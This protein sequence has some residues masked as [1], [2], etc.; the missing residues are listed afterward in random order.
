MELVFVTPLPTICWPGLERPSPIPL[1]FTPIPPSV[2]LRRCLLP[3]IPLV[4]AYS[5][6]MVRKLYLPCPT[7][8]SWTSVMPG[9][10]ERKSGNNPA[11]WVMLPFGNGEHLSVIFARVTVLVW[12]TTRNDK[13]LFIHISWQSLCYLIGPISFFFFSTSSR[14]IRSSIT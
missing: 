1:L 12:F 5:M 13:V 2:M 6:R 4:T 3:T 11:S 14:R 8:A 9:Q 7:T 10:R